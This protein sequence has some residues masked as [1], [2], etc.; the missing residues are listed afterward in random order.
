[1][2]VHNA[3][4]VIVANTA[5]SLLINDG[6]NVGLETRSTDTGVPRLWT[7]RPEQLFDFLE[8]LA[9]GLGVREERL[10]GGSEAEYAENDERLPGNVVEC[11]RDEETEGEVEEPVGDTG[12][13][14]AVRTGLERPDLR[15]VHPGNRSE[16]E[17]VDDD[18]KVG[19]CN[20]A[21]GW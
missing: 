13:G 10:R 4:P 16:S 15:C 14:H 17:R 11:R 3:A 12:N 6:L 20:D 18:Q 1:M 2:V 9:R 5:L 8:G 21:V 7:A 19:E